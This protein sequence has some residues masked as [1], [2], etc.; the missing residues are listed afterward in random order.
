MRTS[1]QK[2]W[3]GNFIVSPLPG[4]FGFVLSCSL[5]ACGGAPRASSNTVANGPSQPDVA[6]VD[7]SQPAVEIERTRTGTVSRA[8]LLRTLDA[9]VGAFLSNVDVTPQLTNG[10]F[11]GWTIRT[12]QSP[13]IDLVPGDVVTAINQQTLETPT[14]AQK[15][16]TSLRG[17]DEIRVAVVRRGMPFELHFRVDG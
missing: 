7:N 16:W 14:D 17:A 9:G 5:A 10:Q 1:M 6:V 3:F 2:P 13:W 11:R 12:F 15:V 4:L 8:E